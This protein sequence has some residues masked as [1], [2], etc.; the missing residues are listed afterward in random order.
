MPTTPHRQRPLRTTTLL[1]LAL[2][3]PGCA[4][5]P[6]TIRVGAGPPDA[7][8]AQLEHRKGLTVEETRLLHGYFARTRLDVIEGTAPDVTGRTVGEL[9]EDERRWERSH[10]RVIAERRQAAAE[11]KARVHMVE[12]EMGHA[13]SVA[14]LETAD[15]QGAG[16]GARKRGVMVKLQLA[17]VGN[18]TIVQV[19]GA[20]RFADVYGRDLFDGPV[21]VR[22]AIP[23]GDRIDRALLLDCAPFMDQET[24]TSQV[25]LADTKATWEPRAI[26]FEDGGV[27]TLPEE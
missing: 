17:N 13:L 23:A 6:K 5:D 27:L 24:R 21:L 16:A 8:L 14:V 22:E 11:W 15:A 9:I 2:G 12:T 1:L 18:R 3:F 25:R 7:V 26:H 10:E 4:G 20:V 19:E